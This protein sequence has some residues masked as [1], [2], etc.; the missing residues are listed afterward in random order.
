MKFSGGFR[1]NYMRRPSHLSTPLTPNSIF[2]SMLPRAGWM[3]D[4]HTAF[5]PSVRNSS[6]ATE[7]KA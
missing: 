7:C 5:D 6:Y 3:G 1:N 2:A 4:A